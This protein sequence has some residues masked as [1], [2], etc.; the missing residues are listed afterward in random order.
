MTTKTRL[1]N[2]AQHNNHW[3]VS[4]A[5]VSVFILLATVNFS[6]VQ[7]QPEATQKTSSILSCMSSDTQ[8]SL[9][10]AL[11]ASGS[12]HTELLKTLE[13]VKKEHLD[14]AVF[15]IAN[16]PQRD[17]ESLKADFLV[18]QIELAYA[19]W[20]KSPWHNKIPKQLFL[21][22]ILPCAHFNERRD[23][24][25][26]DFMDRLSEK[27]WSFRTPVEATIWLNNEMNDMFKV[28][29]H[30]TK[31][32]KPD[33]SP[34]ESIEAGYASC[35]GLSILLA[36]ACRSV[37]IPARIVGVPQW[38]EIQGNHNWVEIWDG[39]WHNV[40]G[41]GS[42][43]RDDDWVNERCRTQTDP[44]RPEHSI[45]AA[46]FRKTSLHYPLVWDDTIDYVPAVNVTRFYS[47]AKDVTIDIPGDNQGTVEIVWNDEII[48]RKS[49][50]KSVP[51]K[52]AAD[53]HYTVTITTPNGEKHKQILDL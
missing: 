12:N 11:D 51:F 38:T 31:R 33:Q 10:K 1:L 13:S 4:T 46:C 26:R 41:T 48:A 47:S 34:Y 7:A 29:Y 2:I 22:Y 30:A 16:M 49:G 50:K 42:D 14:A 37:G 36:D 43:P 45:Y 23:N 6:P 9:N 19:A 39:Q 17:L 8:E 53:S 5:F 52:L 40:G 15:L 25:R 21:Q 18:E 28:Y 35:T 44:N 3:N 20:E 27:A 24:W 32:P